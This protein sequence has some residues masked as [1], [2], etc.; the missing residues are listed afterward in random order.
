MGSVKLNLQE[1]GNVG[2][3][4]NRDSGLLFMWPFQITCSFCLPP[5]STSLFY[6]GTFHMNVSYQPLYISLPPKGSFAI[7]QIWWVST[8][9]L[10]DAVTFK[11]FASALD[12][13][14][15]LCRFGVGA[16]QDVSDTVSLKEYE[17]SIHPPPTFVPLSKVA[18]QGLAH[19]EL[20]GSLSEKWS[21]HS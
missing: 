1:Y 4:R 20:A 8:W 3:I 18:S 15:R 12:W 2:T 6:S 7:S 13:V 9:V 11:F 16:W 10:G 17:F 14:I 19:V 5:F 21:L